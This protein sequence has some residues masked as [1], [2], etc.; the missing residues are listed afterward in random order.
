MSPNCIPF[1]PL[2]QLTQ[3]VQELTEAYARREKEY[4][5]FI[6]SC[7]REEEAEERA[8]REQVELFDKEIQAQE[9]ELSKESLQAELQLH[10]QHRDEHD[11]MKK[12]HSAE[13]ESMKDQYHARRSSVP[14]RQSK[15]E[16]EE[17]WKSKRDARF[18]ERDRVRADLIAKNATE[19]YKKALAEVERIFDLPSLKN[20]SGSVSSSA[21]D[22]GKRDVKDRKDG[23]RGSTSRN[24][25]SNSNCNSSSNHKRP[26]NAVSTSNGD[27]RM[28]VDPEDG[29]SSNNGLDLETKRTPESTTS[30][31]TSASKPTLHGA[32]RQKSDEPIQSF[33]YLGS[34]DY[35]LRVSDVQTYKSLQQSR[36]PPEGGG[37]ESMG[38]I[39]PSKQFS[40]KDV[41][42][43]GPTPPVFEPDNP[44]ISVNVIYFNAEVIGTSTSPGGANT[45]LKT[46]KASDTEPYKTIRIRLIQ[47]ATTTLASSPSPSSSTSTSN[48]GQNQTP[49]PLIR[50][51]VD[52][53]GDPQ[54]SLHVA[55][56]R[57]IAY[58]L[59]TR[60]F[61]AGKDEYGSKVVK[62]VFSEVMELAA[63]MVWYEKRGAEVVEE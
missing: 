44:T 43:A 13:A 24:S 10:E 26:W 57:H 49:G 23:K 45:T 46:W 11:A 33:D 56:L 54:F 53:N 15:L 7:D 25:N 9:F 48:G 12:R 41:L 5:D 58:N 47:P 31:S 14:A 36:G 17:A 55:H 4:N 39:V 28:T 8:R 22:L 19:N 40:K 30:T 50:I 6:A 61:K 27:S 29:S 62:M 32:K 63:C 42:R 21:V 38:S 52:S 51:F 59:S 37:F 16:F 1:D 2:P 60:R 34:I 3:L 20:G 35:S 18:A